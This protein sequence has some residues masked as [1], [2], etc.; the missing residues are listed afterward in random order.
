MRDI[1]VLSSAC[2]AFF[3]PGFFR[4][5][6]RNHER[7]IRIIGCDL[8]DDALT[9]SLFVDKYYQVPRYTEASYVDVLLDICK[10]EQVDV[11]FPHISME[12]PYISERKDDFEKLGVKVAISDKDTLATANCKYH[13]YEFMKREGLT[14]PRY[15]LVDSSATLRRRI[16]ELGFPKRPVCVKMTENSG[17]RGVRIVRADISKSELFMQDKPSS[18]NV[19]LEEMCEILDDCKPMPT[20]MAM[21]FLPG[22][23]YTVDMLADHGKTLYIA[24][25]RN[26]TSSMSIAQTS[27]VEKK[28]SAYKLCEDIVRELRLDGN[29]GFD[30]M[31]DENDTPWLTDLNP[32]VTATIILYAG[33]GMNFPYLRVKQLLGEE[34]PKV[35]LKYGT[36]LVRKYMD[37]LYDEKGRIQL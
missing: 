34:M 32:R 24:G 4:C 28:G 27:I 7:N 11:F 20:I 15:F 13:L 22:V 17:S 26:T 19:T 18:M 10:K 5:L 6:K 16:G 31:L 8:S 36:R 14:V 37:V 9:N 29:I 33:A 30:F 21:E 25:R 35:K 23:E 1:S 12:L 3:M 2:G